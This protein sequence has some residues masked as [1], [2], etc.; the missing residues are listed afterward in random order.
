MSR[1]KN[2]SIKCKLFMKISKFNNY[3]NE[4]SNSKNE[5]KLIQTQ[6]VKD[7]SPIYRT[8]KKKEIEFKQPN[9]GG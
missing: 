5:V 7:A 1:T 6:Q 9:K 3:F 4:Y 8:K 2:I